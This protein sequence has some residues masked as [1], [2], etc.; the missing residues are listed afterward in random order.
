VSSSST[1][2]ITCASGDKLCAGKCVSTGDPSYGCA[3]TTCTPCSSMHATAGCDKNGACTAMCQTGFAN[4]DGLASNGCESDTT[5]DPNNCGKCGMV[6]PGPAGQAVCNNSMCGLKCPTGFADC[7]KM[8]ND[9]CE[10]PITTTTDCGK[11]GTKCTNANGSTACTNGACVPTCA[12]N[13]GDC[14]N[15]ANDGCETYLDTPQ[16]CGQCGPAC[17]PGF[18]CLSINDDPSQPFACGCAAN[19]ANCNNNAPPQSFVCTSLQ[20]PDKCTCSGTL[21]AFGQRCNSN[22][23]CQ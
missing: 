5:T 4:C 12:A 18:D 9:G 17:A 3:D 2:S 23:Q 19:N 10:T 13:Y 6:C 20:G 8:A 21:C 11:C 1:T 22:G 14:N 16:N 15:N 7:N